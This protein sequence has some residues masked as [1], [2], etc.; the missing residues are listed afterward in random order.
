VEARPL[1]WAEEDQP[2][3]SEFRRCQYCLYG[4]RRPPDGQEPHLV[5][6]GCQ[7]ALNEAH[8]AL[9]VGV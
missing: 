3:I 2:I 9:E 7:V 5:V 6:V 8:G 4:F 1:V